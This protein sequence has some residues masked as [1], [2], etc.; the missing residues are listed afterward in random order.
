MGRIAP[1]R[2]VIVGGGFGGASLAR[3]LKRHAP[4]IAV[5]LIERDR[6][7]PRAPFSNGVLGGL[8][9][10][11]RIRFGYDGL[12]AA[13]IE[14]IHDTATALDPATRQVARAAGGSTAISSCFRRVSSSTGRPSRD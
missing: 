5:T 2:V 1:A 8:W 12:S 4:D 13:G 7:H 9:P 14:V 6:H 10:L 11:E 3:A